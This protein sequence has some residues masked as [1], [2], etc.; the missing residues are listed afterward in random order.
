MDREFVDPVL[1]RCRYVS[2]W[3]VNETYGGFKAECEY[4]I[5]EGQFISARKIVELAKRSGL[6]VSL[7][8]G[9]WRVV[10]RR[11][12]GEEVSPEIAEKLIEIL[13]KTVGR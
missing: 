1:G 6:K 9:I 11:G 8:G 13:E 10:G 7:A 3:I 5:F 2:F 4:G 12:Y